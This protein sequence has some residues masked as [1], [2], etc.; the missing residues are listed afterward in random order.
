VV[1]PC[2]GRPRPLSHSRR[3][4]FLLRYAFT[5]P[6]DKAQPRLITGATD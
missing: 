5:R 1:H 4:L 6:G 2:A 3:L